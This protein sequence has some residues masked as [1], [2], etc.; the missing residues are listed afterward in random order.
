MCFF[1]CLENVRH[2]IVCRDSAEYGFRIRGSRPVI[3]SV[4]ESASPAAYSGL[5]VGDVILCINNYN[6]LSASH[7]DVLKIF[8]ECKVLFILF[9]FFKLIYLFCK[10]IVSSRH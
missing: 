9:I 6:V 5:E 8:Q 4:V 10:T 7:S 2:V 3:V 1:K